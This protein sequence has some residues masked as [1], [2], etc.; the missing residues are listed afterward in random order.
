MLLSVLAIYHTHNSAHSFVWVKP[1]QQQRQLF[2]ENFYVTARYFT[3]E[4]SLCLLTP[5]WESSSFLG[6]NDLCVYNVSSV[7]KQSVGGEFCSINIFI[8]NLCD[9]NVT[10]HYTPTPFK[11]CSNAFC[12]NLV[13]VLGS[14]LFRQ[15]CGFRILVFYRKCI[16]LSFLSWY[17]IFCEQFEHI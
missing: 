4:G 13:E 7:S 5:S 10:P 6:C 9:L 11:L 2:W 17:T 8:I 3:T 15:I 1:T 12:W 14:L 16:G